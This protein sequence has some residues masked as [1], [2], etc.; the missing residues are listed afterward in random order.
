MILFKPRAIFGLCLWPPGWALGQ[1]LQLFKLA[2]PQSI[3]K[4]KKKKGNQPYILSETVNQLVSRVPPQHQRLL[5]SLLYNSLMHVL[6][7]GVVSTSSMSDYQ[8]QKI[9]ENFGTERDPN[10]TI[11]LCTEYFGLEHF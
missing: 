6:K 5:H 11:F 10:E 4:K 3:F 9:L 1:A 7:S 2:D 8:Y